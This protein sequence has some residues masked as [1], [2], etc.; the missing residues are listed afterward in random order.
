MMMTSSIHSSIS[1]ALFYTT[2][3]NITKVPGII[4]NSLT[5]FSTVK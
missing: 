5:T 1:T 4:R 2:E 3:T